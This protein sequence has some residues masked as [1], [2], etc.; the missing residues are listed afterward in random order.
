[1]RYHTPAEKEKKGTHQEKENKDIM[2]TIT[3]SRTEGQGD[4]GCI[5][6]LLAQTSL[7]TRS[8]EKVSSK[9]NHIFTTT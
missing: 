1:V 9:S 4:V 7:S 5:L 2:L 3:L 6:Q 8:L